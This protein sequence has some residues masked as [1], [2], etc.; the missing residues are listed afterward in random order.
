VNIFDEVTSEIVDLRDKKFTMIENIV[1]SDIESFDKNELLAYTVLCYFANN[2]TKQCFPSMATIS[3]HMR[4]SAETTRKAIKGLISKGVIVYKTRKKEGSDE[5]ASNVY[6][7][8]DS[9]VWNDVSKK[10][11]K[12]LKARNEVYKERFKD[13]PKK[14]TKKKSVSAPT[15]TLDS[16]DKK[17]IDNSIISKSGKEYTGNFKHLKD[18]NIAYIEEKDFQLI[19]GMNEAKVLEAIKSTLSKSKTNSYS[20]FKKVYECLN[21]IN[22][23]QNE[24]KV[25]TVKTRFHNITQTFNKYAPDE[26]EVILQESQVDKFKENVEPVK[27]LPI[28][29]NENQNKTEWEF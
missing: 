25:P 13:V 21:D 29:I 28:D 3:K 16:S 12:M 6:A 4:T 1:I 24:N 26:L 10:N 27:E 20:Y 5:L 22:N 2:N 15:D 14:N 18:N 11:E 19:Q 17:N 23:K 9:K 7:I 8:M